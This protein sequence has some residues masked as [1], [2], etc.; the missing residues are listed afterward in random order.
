M[1][2]FLFQLTEKVWTDLKYQFG[3]SSE[4]GGIRTLPYVFTE[5]GVAMLS[6][7]L[8]TDRA[9]YVS[10]KIMQAFVSMRKFLLNNTSVYQRSFFTLFF[11]IL[12]HN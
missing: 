2:L 4:F 5:Q 1:R 9:I 6:T 8:S 7:V 12:N 3:T 10:I 11:V